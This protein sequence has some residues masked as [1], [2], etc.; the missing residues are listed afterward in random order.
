MEDTTSAPKRKTQV[1]AALQE[2]QEWLARVLADPG[3]SLAAKAVATR[4]YLH[5]NTST[6]QCNPRQSLLA[7]ETCLSIR[8]VS[9]AVSSLQAR[10][11]LTAIRSDRYGSS[12][13]VLNVDREAADEAGGIRAQPRKG[14]RGQPRKD[15]RPAAGGIRAQPR[16]EQGKGT[17]KEQESFN[18]TAA[19]PEI[20]AD[21]H[22]R[23]S[24]GAT[25]A[26]TPVPAN[27]DG[28][29]VGFVEIRGLKVPEALLEGWA[30]AFPALK[31]KSAVAQRAGWALKLPEARR[32]KA[33]ETEL[34]KLN[35]TAH[36]EQAQIKAKAEAEV[37]LASKP[38][39]SRFQ[40]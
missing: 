22:G 14:I 36:H 5:H 38:P 28:A 26:A 37:L 8:T 16:T 15:T 17:A 25:T 33:L 4:L 3:L 6:G 39:K 20:P 9:E 10:G 19:E 23:S 31:I 27:D 40:Y 13:Y 32:M 12:D 1:P 11:W 34:G 7:D 30:V 24:Q 29:G 2:K 21:M 35:A 18:R